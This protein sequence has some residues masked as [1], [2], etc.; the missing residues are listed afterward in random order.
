M[1]TITKRFQITPLILVALSTILTC[2]SLPGMPAPWLAWVAM[3]PLFVAAD[4]SSKSGPV[5]GTW[6]F[7]WW[8]WSTVW[9]IPAA[10][11]FID[12]PMLLAGTLWL[13]VCLLL[14]LPYWIA[15]MLWH[16]IRHSR[17][18]FLNSLL[19]AMLLTVLAS[20]TQWL[21]PATP[22]HSLYMYP[23]LI[24]IVDIG[25]I[26]L[27]L[28]G[29][30][31]VNLTL[32]KALQ[33]KQMPLM[34][35]TACSVLLIF[36][37]YGHFRMLQLQ[38]L[39]NTNSFSIAMIQPNLQREDTLTPLFEL[40]KDI[41]SE[42]PEIDLVV[43]PEIPPAFSWQES[44]KD[45]KQ[46]TNLLNIIQKPLLLNS[47]YIYATAQIQPSPQSRPRP[48]YNAAQ[49]ISAEGQLLG[50]Y[51]KQRLVPLFEYLPFEKALP[52]LRQWFPN[53]LHY[54]PG[55]NSAPLSL[56]QNLSIAPL[57]C[58]EVLFPNYGKHLVNQGANIFINLSND[59]WFKN[60][61]GSINHFAL[62][63]FRTIESRTPWVRVS[64]G[65]I[66]ASVSA[67]GK[68]NQQ[69]I[70]TL[71]DTHAQVVQ[72]NIQPATTLYQ[73]VGELFLILATLIIGITLLL[74]VKN[75][76]FHTIESP[77]TTYQSDG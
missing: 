48:Y 58:F 59:S 25:G 71:N 41:V 14:A 15:G 52:T 77:A 43:W 76:G 35:S 12:L 16:R 44:A 34:I 28:F 70:T 2:L 75:R 9:L 63:L 19:Q 30:I 18:F 74:T 24:Q 38:P 10:I 29:L 8:C 49:L 54:I 67:T 1:D 68:I 26:P 56:H 37:G 27:L 66:S 23:Q 69:S 42:N 39:E 17:S 65:G 50:S 53:T 22:A 33:R 3:V 11:N 60:S 73:I 61:R 6:A 45:R 64:N 5:L 51:H 46:V 13:L 7:L 21:V 47:G 32:A 4:T 31:T 57:I 20:S 72:V 62:A 55:T 36:A 40:T